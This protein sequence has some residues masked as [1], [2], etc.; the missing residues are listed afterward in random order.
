[1]MVESRSIY[2]LSGWESN[3]RRVSQGSFG[4]LVWLVLVCEKTGGVRTGR[5]DG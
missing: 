4:L 5:E 3:K 2:E 1:M